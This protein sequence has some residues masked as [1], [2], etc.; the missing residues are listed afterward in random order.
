MAGDEEKEEEWSQENE[1]LGEKFIKKMI[2]RM[3]REDQKEQ[4]REKSVRESKERLNRAQTQQSHGVVRVIAPGVMAPDYGVD[5]GATILIRPIENG[6]LISYIEVA[7]P[8]EPAAIP[9][10]P[11]ENSG[12]RFGYVTS[13][14]G[15]PYLSARKV[16]VFVKDSTEA[17]P[18]VG[19]A[20]DAA[21]ALHK[22]QNGG[23]SAFI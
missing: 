13:E 15:N 9:Q 11:Q 19:K 4:E 8:P 3:D 12:E 2:S 21:R 1:K 16:E 17:V 5:G 22:L 14:I 18:V 7:C 10:P 6:F 23:E 20:M